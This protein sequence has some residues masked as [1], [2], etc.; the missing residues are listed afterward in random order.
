[1]NTTVR[2]ASSRDR[3]W[4][5][6]Y[7]TEKPSNVR[8]MFL[9][10]LLRQAKPFED[11]SEIAH[12]TKNVEITLQK[13]LE[14]LELTSHDS[15]NKADHVHMFLSLLRPLE[16]GSSGE[17]KLPEVEPAVEVLQGLVH[18]IYGKLGPRMHKLAVAQWE[19]R[20]RLTSAGCKIGA[21][22]IIVLNPTANTCTIQVI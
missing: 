11:E 19:M 9:R 18:S 1:V 8:R 14:E 20:L 21:W 4:H 15:N 12:T 3:Q 10:T 13:A 7:V 22:R 6:Y 17:Q 16:I 2:Y 5:I